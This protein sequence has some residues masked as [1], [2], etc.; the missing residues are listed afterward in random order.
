MAK[1]V[2]AARVISLA[3]N[4]VSY[5]LGLM[6]QRIKKDEAIIYTSREISCSHANAGA[7][8]EAK[9]VGCKC[10]HDSSKI[11]NHPQCFPPITDCKDFC[12]FLKPRQLVTA[13]MIVVYVPFAAPVYSG[14]VAAVCYVAKT[15]NDT[16]QS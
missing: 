13:S 9:Q 1:L 14:N 10:I 8:N 4:G 6:Q 7:K 5:F 12:N 15:A 3:V 16:S 2:I 11:F